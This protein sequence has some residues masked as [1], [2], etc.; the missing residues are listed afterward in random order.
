[1]KCLWDNIVSISLELVTTSCCCFSETIS[2][3][4]SADPLMNLE[5]S[6]VEEERLR[7]AR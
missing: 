3:R 1:M 2:E 4:D 6:V 5:E 7:Q